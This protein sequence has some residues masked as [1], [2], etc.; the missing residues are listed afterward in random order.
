MD[1]KY[2]VTFVGDLILGDHPLYYGIG[3][4]SKWKREKID[5]FS[6]V[7][8]YL[9]N[10]DLVVGNLEGPISKKL[11]SAHS[12][13]YFLND[14]S[15]LPLLSRTFNVLSVAN[16]HILQYGADLFYQT[17]EALIS[18]GIDIIGRYGQGILLKNIRNYRVGLIAF[19]MRPEQAL[20]NNN[21][22][23][24]RIEYVEEQLKYARRSYDKLIVYVHWGVEYVK[25]PSKEQIEAAKRL[26][27]AGANYVV[28]H[29]VHVI[30]RSMA[31]ADSK[32]FFGLGNFV[33]DMCQSDARLGIMP[34]LSFMSKQDKIDIFEYRINTQY[35]PQVISK[36]TFDDY[37]SKGIDTLSENDYKIKIYE[38]HRKFRK[39]Y[40]FFLLKSLWKF[41]LKCLIR[42]FHDYIKRIC[43]R[44]TK[45]EYRKAV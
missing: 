34:S 31:I 14:I 37:I 28:G 9:H 36:K 30:Q 11:Y 25:I 35:Q 4:A 33:S 2:D 40:I 1:N 10:S 27:M 32:I 29:H 18:Y 39:D 16:N 43:R 20:S 22:Y 3:A 44:V 15:I 12:I 38:S 5:Y 17:I 24:H 13:P 8:R 42:I 7:R 21:F 41:P 26:V 23:E 45:N 6:Y 19:S